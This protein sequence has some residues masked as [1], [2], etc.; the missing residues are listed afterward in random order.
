M[1]RDR[2]S[3][4]YLYNFYVWADGVT[5]PW[6]APGKTRKSFLNRENLQHILLRVW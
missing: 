1:K 3:R 4:D 6:N 2:K 5:S